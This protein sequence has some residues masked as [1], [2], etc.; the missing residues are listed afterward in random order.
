MP[1]TP[2][3]DATASQDP[4]TLVLCGLWDMADN[5]APLQGL[6]A[7]GNRIKFL[8][9]QRQEPVKDQ[10]TDSDRPELEIVPGE[11]FAELDQTT[12]SDLWK[13]RWN[14]NVRSSRQQLD[15]PSQ[16]NGTPIDAS[17]FPVL[18]AVLQTFMGYGQAIKGTVT[19]NGSPFVWMVKPGVPVLSRDTESRMLGWVGT[20]PFY[21]WLRIDVLSNLA[22]QIP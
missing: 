13:V 17:L 2:N 15:R 8:G 4:F 14:F 6:V 22:S 11:P 3:L 18:W 16:A 21:T 1:A 10:A 19:L 20:W 5:S 9:Q 7:M 12:G